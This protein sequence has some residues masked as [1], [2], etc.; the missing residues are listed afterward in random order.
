VTKFGFSKVG[1]GRGA[2]RSSRAQ[3]TDLKIC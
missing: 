3:A 1:I 2:L